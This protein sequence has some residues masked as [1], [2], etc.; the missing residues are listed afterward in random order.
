MNTPAQSAKPVSVR[1]RARR[2]QA[3]PDAPGATARSLLIYRPRTDFARA[4]SP[5]ASADPID[6]GRL[7]VALGG[8][9]RPA[10]SGPW[11]ARRVGAQLLAG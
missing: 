9:S 1:V 2:V 6:A 8:R 7:Q 10:T 5:S 3:S 4:G 11:A